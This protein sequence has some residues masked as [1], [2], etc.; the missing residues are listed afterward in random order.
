MRLT[1]ERLGEMISVRNRYFGTFLGYKKHWRRP[2]HEPSALHV[3]GGKAYF[4]IAIRRYG[5]TVDDIRLGGVHRRKPIRIVR[6][7]SVFRRLD[8]R[9]RRAERTDRRYIFIIIFFC[10]L[11]SFY[12]IPTAKRD[13][14]VDGIIIIYYANTLL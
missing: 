3:R 14:K 4:G 8:A 9:V 10:L 13:R 7:L 11:F 12:L 6:R 5:R 1:G 2:S